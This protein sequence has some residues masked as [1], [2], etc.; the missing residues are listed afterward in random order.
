MY[1]KKLDEVYAYVESSEEGLTS[2]EAKARLDKNGKNIL[3][4]KK[5]KNIAQLFFGEF[6]SPLTI[7][8][9]LTSVFSF[10]IKER[11]DSFVIAAIVLVDAIIGT[12]E[13]YR[14]LKSA[15]ALSNML[16]TKA[17]VLRDGKK[18]EIS[19]EELV[20]GDVVFLES[21]VKVSCDARIIESANLLIDESSLTGES[22]PV[23]KENI[24]IDKDV[25][26]GDRK[27]M[28]YAGTNVMS[29]R[30]VAI[31]VS[32][33]FETELGKIAKVVEETKEEKSPLTI[34]M[35]RFSKQISVMILAVSVVAAALL[36][37]NGYE[38]KNIV[39]SVIAL[40][41]SAMPEGLSLAQ[42]MA[43][44][45]ASK[46]MASENVIVKKLNSVESLGSCTVIASDKTG[47]LTVNE[48]TAKKIVLASGVSFE[49]TGTGY[50]V[51]GEVD[52]DDRKEADIKKAKRIASLCALNNEATFK[53]NVS[54]S[55]DS[56]DIAF[57]V[58]K[59][60]MGLDDEYNVKKSIPYESEKQFSAIYYEEDGK[61]RC[62][63]KGSL[64]KVMSFSKESK[65]FIEQ[66]EE[67]TK[68]GYRVIAVADGEVK[69]DKTL[70][71]LEFLGMV[72]FI[73]PVRE[74]AKYSV[75]ECLNAGIK[76]LMVTGDHPNT[77]LAIAKKLDI[78][79]KKD[80][81]IT[82]L[83]LEEAYRLGEAYFDEV[84]ATKRVFS[85]VTPTDKYHIVESLKRQG[86][87]VAVTG[88]GVNDAPAI[89]AANIGI[90]MGSGTDVAKDTA[91]MIIADD[92][93]SSIVNGV[94]EG[95][96]AYSN[97]RKITLFLI[98]CG[99]AEVLFS[100]LSVIF[101][102]DMPL[103][104]IQLLWLNVVTDGLQ[105][106]A[107]SFETS[108]KEIMQERPRN[109]K[110][111]LFS[112]DLMLE[113]FVFGLT[114]T[115]LVFACWKYMISHGYSDT[116]SRSVIMMLM[117]FIQ[118]VHVLN[119][120]SEK[121]SVLTTS[122][123]SNPLIFLT[124]FGSIGLQIVVTQVPAFAKLLKIES[125]PTNIIITALCYSLIVIFV[126]EVYKALYRTF[127]KKKEE[128]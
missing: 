28:I 21:G 110:E 61:L 95:R 58:L 55:G 36:Y 114:I 88:D 47:T 81:V 2:K 60:K 78:A 24:V 50:N 111:S 64:E 74:E 70:E 12:V 117:V 25:A 15:E 19:A 128:M 26:L 43:L 37:I 102:M 118:N 18:I 97:I 87:F 10:L 39:L 113:V 62:T 48:Q 38:I 4:V 1:K 121:N 34:R 23:N 98:S 122:L 96:V 67:L 31:V 45:V 46:R 32:T 83:E 42:T 82:G 59:E 52:F 75:K 11:I 77:S 3:T 94:R 40:A 66:N 79:T 65:K 14:A 72:A 108:S 8:L 33:S 71:G 115:V 101:K 29:G 20:I 107:L 56:I 109:T 73:D 57:L 86:E 76:V 100:L 126:S 7:I 35:E 63:V 44:T 123:L 41:V 104:A 5:N 90:A 99:F 91:S 124:V 106:I 17:T 51:D 112:F 54:F 30:G 103:L 22:L 92:D 68:E 105:D 69:N 16:V 6:T 13:E 116:Y 27:N 119:C 125:I 80:Q 53:E 84:V 49:V 85:R 127:L 93:F 9:I 120:R 89:K